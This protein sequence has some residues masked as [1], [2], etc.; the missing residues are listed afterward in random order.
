MHMSIVHTHTSGHL[1][2]QQGSALPPHSLRLRPPPPLPHNYKAGT[3]KARGAKLSRD[4]LAAARVSRRSRTRLWAE[5]SPLRAKF[6][7]EA[8]AGEEDCLFGG[9]SR[10]CCHVF[11]SPRLFARLQE[12]PPDAASEAEKAAEEPA[13]PSLR[14]VPH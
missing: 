13:S 6:V 10:R 2:K 4:W 3:G 5:P 11:G 12:A 8:P 7:T 1:C 14:A 9:V